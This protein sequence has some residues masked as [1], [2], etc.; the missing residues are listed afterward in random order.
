[1]AAPDPAYNPTLVWQDDSLVWDDRT[2]EWDAP[3]APLSET[4]SLHF[5]QAS[6]A[7][8]FTLQKPTGRHFVL[9]KG[10]RR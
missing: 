7:R 4:G 8:D 5:L 1:M 3:A 10:F 6:V 2:L 9:Q